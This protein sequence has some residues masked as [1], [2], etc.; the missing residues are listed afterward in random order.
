MRTDSTK[1]FAYA[2]G[3]AAAA[4]FVYALQAPIQAATAYP[5]S[6]LQATTHG[7]F[8]AGALPQE[9]KD[10]SLVAQGKAR[11][12]AYKCYDCHGHNGEGTDDAPDLVGTHKTEDQIAKFLQKPSADA[13]NK[14]MPSIAADSPDLK[15]LVA[16][17]VSLKKAK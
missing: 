2:V 10:D 1:R 12:D 13:E 6:S 11:Y 4:M 7:Y 9:K 8:L 15:P 16:F 3:L 17:V 5:S 14:G